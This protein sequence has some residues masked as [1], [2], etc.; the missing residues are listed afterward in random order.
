MFSALPACAHAGQIK[1]VTDARPKS[2]VALVAAPALLASPCRRLP[3]WLLTSQPRQQVVPRIEHQ[4]VDTPRAPRP[5]RPY[6]RGRRAACAGSVWL[7]CT[8]A[9]R[10]RCW[11]VPLE[12]RRRQSRP[13][14]LLCQTQALAL[15]AA[16]PKAARRTSGYPALQGPRQNV[17]AAAHHPGRR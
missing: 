8:L 14:P 13:W 16:C 7:R 4:R 15:A 10:P 11:P 17:A 9:A 5:R 6:A 12:R 1:F 3:V 2:A